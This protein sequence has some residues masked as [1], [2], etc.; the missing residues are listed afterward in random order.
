MN[1]LGNWF[2]TWSGW[3]EYKKKNGEFIAEKLIGDFLFNASKV[4]KEGS[5]VTLLVNYFAVIG[6]K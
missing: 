3:Q 6:S 1:H 2:K 4:L 5:K